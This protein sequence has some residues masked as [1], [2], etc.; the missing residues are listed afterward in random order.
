MRATDG[1][2]EHVVFNDDAHC[3]VIGNARATGLCGSGLIDLAAEL[4]RTGIASTKGR[5]LPP[6]ELPETVPDALRA[7]VATNGDGEVEFLLAAPGEAGHATPRVT[8]KQKD[9]RELQLAAGAIRAGTRILLKQAGLEPEQVEEV[10]IAGGFGS[11]V[12]RHNAQQIGLLPR[13]IP[14][15]RLRYVGNTSLSGARWALLSTDMRARAEELARVT[16]HVELSN[17]PDFALEFAMA[18]EFPGPGEAL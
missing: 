18:M 7:R 9:L 8:L 14:Q 5:L 10:L 12:R 16:A 13:E 17:H 11:Y 4:L 3:R 1:A 15:D 2:I 6:G